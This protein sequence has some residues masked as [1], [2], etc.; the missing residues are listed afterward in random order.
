MK[1]LPWTKGKQRWR[2]VETELVRSLQH[3]FISQISVFKRRT[4]SDPNKLKCGA[5]LCYDDK[6]SAGVY[7][8]VS[9]I[10]HAISRHCISVRVQ[11]I[12]DS[13]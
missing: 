5:D 9:G 6:Y 7:M 11:S 10:P 4:D 3:L 1:T 8:W 2:W 13:V 12:G